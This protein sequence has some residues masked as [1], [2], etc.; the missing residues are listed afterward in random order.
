M[1]AIEAD[2]QTTKMGAARLHIERAGSAGWRVAQVL[3]ILLVSSGAFLGHAWQEVIGELLHVQRPAVTSSF[4]VAI[5]V[6]AV[7]QHHNIVQ[8]MDLLLDHNSW[9]CA[10]FL[11]LDL[12]DRLD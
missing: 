8:A 10:V 12:L 3:E 2:L 7:P 11:L 4:G 1:L 9:R 6:V 5:V